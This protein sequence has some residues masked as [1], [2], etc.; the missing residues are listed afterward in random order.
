MIT[1][2]SGHTAALRC[3]INIGV[4]KLDPGPKVRPAAGGWAYEMDKIK[5]LLGNLLL[6]L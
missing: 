4:L 2:G 6:N 1:S 5:I 3:N